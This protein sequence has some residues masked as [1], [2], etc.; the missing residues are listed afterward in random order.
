MSSRAL[1][2]GRTLGLSGGG[3]LRI[4]IRIKES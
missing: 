2:I 1:L 4:A 3:L